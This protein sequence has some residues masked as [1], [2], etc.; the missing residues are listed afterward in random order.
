MNSNITISSYKNSIGLLIESRIQQPITTMNEPQLYSRLVE[1]GFI[2]FR[3]FDSSIDLFSEFVREGSSR[4]TIDPMREFFG[5]TAQKVDAGFDAVGMHVEHGNNPFQPDICW[6]Y[7]EKA[8]SEGSQTTVCDGYTVWDQMPENMKADF[9]SKNIK[10]C[11]YIEGVKWKT[12]TKNL[13]PAIANL[14][15]VTVDD[16][17]SLITHPGFRVEL[18]QDDSIYY[19]FETSAIKADNPQGRHSF[20]NSILGPSYN[21]QAPVI[22]FADDSPIDTDAQ[23]LLEKL[24]EESTTDIDWQSGD[25]LVIDNIHMMHGR[26]AILDKDRRL[27]NA[28]SFR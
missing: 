16:F 5:N 4:V 9:G 19:E 15:D 10:Y 6:F 24:F 14:E 20:A 1:S 26:R 22:K 2:L 8:A 27:F 17:R 11:R 18:Q 12:L 3:G 25:V 21:Y 28:M 7:C 13:N 23:Q